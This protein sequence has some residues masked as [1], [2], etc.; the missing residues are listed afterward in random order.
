[1]ALRSTRPM[2]CVWRSAL[3]TFD[4]RPK[5]I[6]ITLALIGLQ[7]WQVVDNDT[8]VAAK[9][10]TN[11]AWPLLAS[12]RG[13]PLPRASARWPSTESSG[14][15]GICQCCGVA[16][17]YL[18]CIADVRRLLRSDG[19]SLGCRIIEPIECNLKVQESVLRLSERLPPLC[20]GGAVSCRPCMF[21]R[22][23][24]R[25]IAMS[26]ASSKQWARIP[27]AAH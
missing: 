12:N 25:T 1:M 8:K 6:I 15:R 24:F 27:N 17:C 13:G 23:E 7:Y 11:P 22:S 16:V 9:I 19:F 26:N 21:F 10:F 14:L 20:H 2:S 18:P 4:S 3:R 5:Y